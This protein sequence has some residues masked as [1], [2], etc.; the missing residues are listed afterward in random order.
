MDI[1]NRTMLQLGE[2]CIFYSI[3]AQLKYFLGS[4]DANNT[5]CRRVV[6]D[7]AAAIFVDWL[8]GIKTLTPKAYY[9]PGF[10]L[11]PPLLSVIWLLGMGH[12]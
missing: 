8:S 10:W 6:N 4:F 11:V 9:Q 1:Q 5:S 3:F 7:A 12:R 2:N